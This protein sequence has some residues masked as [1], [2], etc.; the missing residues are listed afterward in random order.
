MICFDAESPPK[1]GEWQLGQWDEGYSLVKASGCDCCRRFAFEWLDLIQYSIIKVVWGVEMPADRQL[2]GNQTGTWELGLP[3]ESHP[4]WGEWEEFAYK[5]FMNLRFD[6]TAWNC[7]L[8][9][10][11]RSNKNNNRAAGKA[12]KTLGKWITA[13]E[14]PAVTV[15]GF[16][17][18]LCISHCLCPLLI[19]RLRQMHN[20]E[21]LLKQVFNCKFAT[22]LLITQM[23]IHW[24]LLK[25]WLHKK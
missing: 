12:G 9:P 25:K 20:S 11:H 24:V 14:P 1:K 4:Y 7:W 19:I 21:K 13:F 15:F 5:W 22:C 10:S 17:G 3:L 16:L 2:P 6:W 18:A 23:Q 8:V